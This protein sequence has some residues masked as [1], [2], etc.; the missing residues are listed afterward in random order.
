MAIKASGAFLKMSEINDQFLLGNSAGVH[1]GVTWYVDSAATTG[2]FSST[3]LKF[4]DFY[5]KRKTDPAGGGSTTYSASGSFTV[6]LFR[7]SLVIDAWG[8]GG[9][10]GG[11]NGGDT[12]V[13]V[14]TGTLS[15]GGGKG[16]GGGGRR[17]TGAGG[18]GGSATG[19]DT[20]QP[21]AAGGQGAGANGGTGGSAGGIEYGG[22]AGGAD[23][24]PCLRER[25]GQVAR[26]AGL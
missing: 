5:S 15:A 7:T 22:G 2:T 19:G 17:T 6:P 20:N 25:A 24:H 9:G 14:S 4:S 26:R 8:G 23:A 11:T 12:S 10:S 3:N 21:G 1:R 13:T 18:A 16:G